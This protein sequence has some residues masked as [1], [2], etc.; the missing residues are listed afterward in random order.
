MTVRFRPGE[1]FSALFNGLG[2]PLSTDNEGCKTDVHMERAVG[3]QKAHLAL[4][5]E[6]EIGDPACIDP[7][8][9]RLPKCML[10]PE[11]WRLPRRWLSPSF[12]RWLSS[13][14]VS[15]VIDAFNACRWASRS[16]AIF[17]MASAFSLLDRRRSCL[18]A[19]KR[20]SL[21]RITRSLCSCAHGR[22]VR[23]KG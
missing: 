22:D 6:E 2:E 1:P 11:P 7:E 16:A 23:K 15:N 12:P 17:A 19:S 18:I 10:L 5:L 9:C 21:L 8:S 13:R 3:R 20:A 4:L 14:I